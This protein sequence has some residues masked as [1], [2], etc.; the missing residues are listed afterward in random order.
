MSSLIFFLTRNKFPELEYGVATHPGHFDNNPTG[1][2]KM[3]ELGISWAR[4]DV[5]WNG[6][7][8][9]KGVFNFSTYDR[10]FEELRSANITMIPIL[11]YSNCLYNAMPSGQGYDCSRYVPAYGTPEWETYKKKWGEFIYQSVKHYS[12][13]Y[14]MVYFEFWNEPYGFWQPSSMTLEMK[15]IMFTELQKEG[16]IRAKE[17]NPKCQVL[18]GSQPNS[19]SGLEGYTRIM[20]VYGVKDYFD[21][22]VIHPYC[23]YRYDSTKPDELQG[24]NCTSLNSDL[25]YLENLMAEYGDSDKEWWITEFG[26]PTEGCYIG[27]GSEGKPV[28][29]SGCDNLSESAQKYRLINAIND[30]KKRKQIT[31]LMWY[32]MK[33]DCANNTKLPVGCIK[34]VI[35]ENCPVYTEC[36]FGLIRYDYSNKPAFLA[37]QEIIKESKE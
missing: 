2:N 5:S 16:Y 23:S 20:Y 18:I 10:Y 6:V 14:G 24:T 8:K 36:R 13:K 26:Y 27:G 12:E 32:D 3:K 1:L 31:K 11:T 19:R 9:T 4:T 29:V 25:D 21:I 35:T 37:Y 15:A 28:S 22:M 7:E 17:A 33:D 34:D 30:I